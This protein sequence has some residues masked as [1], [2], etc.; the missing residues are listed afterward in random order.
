MDEQTRKVHGQAAQLDATALLDEYAAVHTE[1]MHRN[2]IAAF[3]EERLRKLDADYSTFL[4]AVQ[5]RREESQRTVRCGCRLMQMSNEAARELAVEM[6]PDADAYGYPYRYAAGG[7]G[8]SPNASRS[9]VL[10]LDF[11]RAAAKVRRRGD[12][13]DFE[14]DTDGTDGHVHEGD[15]DA[16]LKLTV[17]P[18]GQT[19]RR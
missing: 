8:G 3:H 7:G 10:L 18:L 4:R 16:R 5:R 1:L 14:L 19:I 9:P 17:D 11:E 13:V 2:S 15:A 12:E 6:G